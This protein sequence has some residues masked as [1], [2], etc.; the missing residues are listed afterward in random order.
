M[1][2]PSL[3]AA[4]SLIG[5]VAVAQETNNPFPDPIPVQEGVIVVGFE[6]VANIPDVDRQFARMQT[7]RHEPGTD[8]LFVSDMRGIIYDVNED[9][10][11]VTPYL[12]ANDD[13]WDLDINDSWREV[14][15]QSMAFHPQF[16]ESGTPGYG[17]FYIWTDTNNTDAM[18]AMTAG[19]D[20]AHHTILLEWTAEDPT[21]VAYDGG[22]PREIARFE[23]PYPNH[24]GG[25]IAFNPLAEPGDDD[26]GMLYI[27][28][29]DGGSGGDPLNLSQNTGNALGKIL[30]I[31]PLG[32]DGFNGEYGVPRD[33]PF[34]GDERNILEEIFAIGL[35]NPQHFAWDSA[36]GTMMVSDIGQ[37]TIEKVSV[38]EAGDNLGWRNWEGSFRYVGRNAVSTEDP[39]SDPNIRYPFA[40]YDHHS[41]EYFVD[42]N[43]AVTGLHVVRDSGVPEIEGR[44]LFGDLPSGE[45]FH[46]D[47]DNLPE[48]GQEA[49]RRVLF[50]D[51]SGEVKNL[52]TVLR[53]KNREQGRSL[54]P[55]V[56]LGLGAGAN[57]DVYLLN[58]YDGTLRKL[59]SRP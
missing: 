4:V 25:A 29:G 17:K 3:I 46:V 45:L 31:D 30:R 40:E 27:G 38:V 21:A 44:V 22:A 51:G 32:T 18:A 37:G 7:L 23:Q 20:V 14:G 6:E 53:D 56:D 16:G 8:R 48:G 13:R 43:V 15:M 12:L 54:A 57:G 50:D 47:A 49:I 1:R 59:V 58:K 2:I 24:N 36:T 9:T 41:S 52:M 42:G 10:G 33:N 19:G 26:Y 55:R 34:V 39:R 5:S 35:R 28:N 11:A